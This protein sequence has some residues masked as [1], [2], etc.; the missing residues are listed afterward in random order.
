MKTRK[1]FL[2][3]AILRNPALEKE[4]DQPRFYSIRE[5]DYIYGILEKM[6]EGGSDIKVFVEDFKRLE[7]QRYEILYKRAVEE[8]YTISQIGIAIDFCAQSDTKKREGSFLVD[9]NLSDY[10][11]RSDFLWNDITNEHPKLGSTYYAIIPTFIEMAPKEVCLTQ[12]N[13]LLL[14]IKDYREVFT[15]DELLELVVEAMDFGKEELDR[16][17][18]EFVTAQVLYYRTLLPIA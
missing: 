7:D 16:Q 13:A 18:L 14:D 1:N 4:V 15:Y 8:I 10:L 12:L 17:L 5:Q 2:D 3:W 6:T 11:V 9:P